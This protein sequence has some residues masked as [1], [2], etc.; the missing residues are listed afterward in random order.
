MPIYQGSHAYFPA[1]VCTFVA[2][3][4]TAQLVDKLALR[5]EYP[6][7]LHVFE[8][9]FMVSLP[10]HPHWKNC[11]PLSDCISTFGPV[12]SMSLCAE[13]HVTPDWVFSRTGSVQGTSWYAPICPPN[14]PTPG[15][16]AS[17]LI[18]WIPHALSPI[19]MVSN[20]ANLYGVPRHLF[21]QRARQLFSI[22]F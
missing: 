21:Q 5:A 20:S 7:D 19:S 1:A 13:N 4:I 9:I 14:P 6:A 16:P 8:F 18:C 11:L 15:C 22:P 2:C 10:H 3:T 12:A 17:G